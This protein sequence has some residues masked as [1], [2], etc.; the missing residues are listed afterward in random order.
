AD[1]VPWVQHGAMGRWL[2]EPDMSVLP[3]DVQLAA[4]ELTQ[5]AE[6]G[7]R[8]IDMHLAPAGPTNDATEHDLV[9]VIWQPERLQPQREPRRALE[10]GLDH[11]L[12]GPGANAAGIR[13]RPQEQPQGVAQDALS[14]PALPRQ[15]RQARPEADLDL[16]DDR[17]VLDAQGEQHGD[18]EPPFRI[19]PYPVRPTLHKL[20]VFSPRRG[21]KPTSSPFRGDMPR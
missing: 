4:H 17:E 1:T 5:D 15:D 6:R 8:A 9:A 12:L 18:T 13:P 20:S 10:D 11:R 21:R 7:Q 14:G 3:G 2:E 16:L 19:T